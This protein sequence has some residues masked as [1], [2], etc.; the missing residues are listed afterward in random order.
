MPVFDIYQRPGFLLRRA[1]QISTAI[2]ERSCAHLGLTPAQYG[3]LSVVAEQ[4]GVDQSSLARALAF[5]KVTV[6]RVLQGLEAKGLCTRGTAPGNRRQMA[7]SLTPQGLE[8]LSLARQPVQQ[9]ADLL[10]SPFTP[11]QREQFMGLLNT[12]NASLDAQAR[13]GFVPVQG[14]PVKAGKH[15]PSA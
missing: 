11:A 4:P 5:D 6:L 9:A 13:A 15:S 1:H 12:L 2:F 8:L 3:V 10:L 7:V 14:L